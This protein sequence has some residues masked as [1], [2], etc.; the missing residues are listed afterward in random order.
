MLRLDA[1]PQEIAELAANLCRL[2][3]DDELAFSALFDPLARP[4][5]VALRSREQRD[6][7]RHF[8]LVEGEDSVF[9]LHRIRHLGERFYIMELGDTRE[10]HQD[11]W[12]ET[13]ALLACLE[14][15]RPGSLLDMGTGTGIVAIEGA[16]RGHKVVATDL[17]A[18]ALALALFNALLNRLE[19]RIEFRLGHLFE[20]VKD[21]RFDLI[22]TAPHYTRVNDQ[23]R[24]EALRTAPEHIALGGRLLVATQLEWEGENGPLPVAELLLRPLAA[25]GARVEVAPIF[26]PLKREWFFAAHADPPIPGLVSRHRFLVTITRPE[27]PPGNLEIIRPRLDEQPR[28]GFVPLEQ[29][30]LGSDGATTSFPWPTQAVISQRP[31]LERLEDLLGGLARGFVEIGAPVPFGL[32]DACR[33]GAEPCISFVDNWGAAGAILALDGQVRPCCHG[34]ALGRLNDSLVQWIERLRSASIEAAERRGCTDCEASQRCSR[35]LS[36]H[37]L[38][39]SEYC[40]FIRAHGGELP[41]FHRALDILSLLSSSGPLAGGVRLKLRTDGPLIVAPERPP[42]LETTT[43]DEAQPAIERVASRWAPR[44]VWLVSNQDRYWLSW[45]RD[46][47]FLLE[48][49]SRESADLMELAAA[50]VPAATLRRYWREQ[51]R[52]PRTLE[53]TLR[54]LDGLLA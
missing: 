38:D 54:F 44:Q 18:S 19:A 2:A 21:E 17:Y 48:S 24:L 47:R 12:P 13:D 5:P 16:A 30:R 51:L 46:E 25:A 9:S 26:M 7:L 50:G 23:L 31:D 10:Y 32:L 33:F 42:T 40:R 53:R 6:V 14:D 3:A 11:V 1:S 27:K 52:A 28:R 34:E 15:A 43:V 35:C 49:L 39:E 4:F 45:K 36:P 22:L 37:P 8:N 29:L 20:P 41:L